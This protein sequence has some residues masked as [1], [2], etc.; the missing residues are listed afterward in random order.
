MLKKLLDS[1]PTFLDDGLEGSRIRLGSC[2]TGTGSF[3]S[4]PQIEESVALL[5][6]RKPPRTVSESLAF[7][8]L[9]LALHILVEAYSLSLYNGH[10]DGE[11]GLILVLN[12]LCQKLLHPLHLHGSGV[13]EANVPATALARILSALALMVCNVLPFSPIACTITEGFFP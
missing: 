1:V 13:E 12:P 7:V 6:I 2:Y 4:H 9:T 10:A 3:P 5:E 11:I 8:F